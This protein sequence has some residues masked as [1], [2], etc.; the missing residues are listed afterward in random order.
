MNVGNDLAT[1]EADGGTGALIGDPVRNLH[2]FHAG[3]IGSDLSA[4]IRSILPIVRRTAPDASAGGGIIAPIEHV[5]GG[6]GGDVEST[7]E[8]YT[9]LGNAGAWANA[10]GGLGPSTGVL[11]K[12]QQ[13]AGIGGAN[14]QLGPQADFAPA[15]TP[16]SSGSGGGGGMGVFLLLALAI[17][18]GLVYYHFKH[19]KGTSEAKAA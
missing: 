7:L 13:S 15:G 11:D 12:L 6:A 16:G 3:A 18:G 2:I 9:G 8:T 1:I 4:G 14:L 10:V 19:K 5:T 17:V